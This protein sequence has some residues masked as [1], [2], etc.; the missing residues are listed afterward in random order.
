LLVDASE[1]LSRVIY[2]EAHDRLVVDEGD[3]PMPKIELSAGTIDYLDTGGP[4]PV[5]VPVHGL[6][7]DATV[8]RHV[9]DDLRAD[10]R[11]VVPTLPLGAHRTAMYPDADLSLDGQAHLLAELIDRLDLRDVTLV[12]NDWGGPQVTAVEH[13]ELIERLVLTPCEAF[14]NLPPGLPGR[15]AG[16][17]GR[18]PGGLFMAAQSLRIPA[19]RRL[20]MTF[21]W[22]TTGPIPRDLFDPWIEPLCTQRAVR[23]DLAK[24]VRTTDVGRLDALAADLV[25]LDM[26]A[27]VAWAA[28]DRMMPHEH[29]PRLSELLPHGHFVEV[30]DSRTLMPLDQPAVL[31][32]LV[33]SFIRAHPVELDDHVED[34]GGAGHAELDDHADD[35]GE[36]AGRVRVP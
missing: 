6:L 23:R 19:A 12:A 16:L 22:M 24:Y 17:A 29:G 15:F 8:W 32:G 31:A 33:R 27:L 28:D 7:M 21:G 9:V 3:A 20:P 25:T 1:R 2:L 35:G 18:L 5:V 14:D 26:P 34:G 4:G 36:H 30:C 11:C 10:H 13:P